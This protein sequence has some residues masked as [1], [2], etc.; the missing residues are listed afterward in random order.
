MAIAFRS[1]AVASGTA[2]GAEPSGAQQGDVLV[3]YV[4]CWGSGVHTPPSGWTEHH[5]ATVISVSQMSVCTITRGASAPALNWT[6]GN[7]SQTYILILAF[8]GSAGRDTSAINTASNSDTN[9]DSPSVTVTNPGSV[10]VA[11][12]FAQNGLISAVP[13]GMTQRATSAAAWVASEAV[14]AGATGARTWTFSSNQDAGSFSLALLPA[15]EASGISVGYG[16]Y[17]RTG[18]AN[19]PWTLNFTG[20]GRINAYQIRTAS[21]GGGTLVASGSA[22]VGANAPTVAYNASGLVQG[23]N[24]LYLRVSGDSGSTFDNEYSFTLLRDD[25]VSAPSGIG[26]TPAAVPPV[27]QYSVTFDAPDAYSTN[28]NE[29]RWEIRTASGGGGTLVGSGSFTQGSSRTTSTVTD[30]TLV[31]GV[32]VR[33]LRIKDGANNAAETQF[34]VLA[35]FLVGDPGED[36]GLPPRLVRISRARQASAAMAIHALSVA[37]ELLPFRTTELSREL[38]WRLGGRVQLSPELQWRLGGT[39][40]QERTLQWRVAPSP[41]RVHYALTGRSGPVSYTFRFERRTIANQFLEDVTPAFLG[42]S[43]EANNDRD[44]F[45]TATFTIDASATDDRGNAVTIDPL[46]DHIAVFMDLLVDGSYTLGL[47]MGLFALNVPRKRFEPGMEMWEIA[48]S[49]NG[50]HLMEATTTASYTVAAAENYIT[51]TNAVRDILDDLGLA[52]ALPTTALTL[53]VARTWP[54]GTPWLR[55]V[56]DLLHAAGMYSLWFDA[57]GIARTRAYDDL[58]TRTPDV[59]YTGE[60]FVLIPIT[61]EAE[62]TRLA[63]Q[64]VAIVDDP[65]RAP[66]TSVKTN[67][68]PDSPI[69][70]VSLGR[71]ITKVIQSDAADQTTLDAIAENYLRNEAGLYRRATLLTS[72][73][74]RREAHEVYELTVDGVY[75]AERWWA[76]NWRVQLSIGAQHQHTLGKVERVTAS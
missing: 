41:L 52:H 61:E 46:A 38:Q 8:S 54:A 62:T 33:Y 22:S 31:D 18:P 58:S 17:T 30:S 45:R 32:N 57:S 76:R 16:S 27:R 70:T 59:T 43:I 21:G 66:L 42:G 47:P 13:S 25:S 24:T 14:G 37:A 36:E 50:I 19:T 10:L 51:G 63:N 39:V 71:T 34:S 72:I 75:A 55:I 69:S 11:G 65:S 53:P 60:D 2:T 3:A 67:A 7:S 44:V 49:D 35:A 20:A 12:V 9:Y 48:A 56:N 68:D 15:A 64:V 6:T 4:V 73:D 26:H 1:A 23:S 28:T 40:V 29:M 5:D 74:P